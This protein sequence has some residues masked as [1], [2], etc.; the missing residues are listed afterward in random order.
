M[1]P[2]LKIN[3]KTKRKGSLQAS[4][5]P[6]VYS[7]T[8][9][10][11]TTSGKQM[12]SNHSMLLFNY[13]VS[14]SALDNHIKLYLSE[15]SI[16]EILDENNFNNTE[17]TYF[18]LSIAKVN[19]SLPITKITLIADLKLLSYS[20]KLLLNDDYIPLIEVNSS[21]FNKFLENQ[22]NFDFLNFNIREV[23]SQT[24]DLDHFLNNNYRIE[25]FDKDTSNDIKVEKKL[26]NG[27][28]KNNNITNNIQDVNDLFFNPND[29]IR[30]NKGN[31]SS[32]N[33]NLTNL[34]LSSNVPS[35]LHFGKMNSSMS[36]FSKEKTSEL[37]FARSSSRVS[38]NNLLP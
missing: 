4:K 27:M 18:L 23:N 17:L 7:M 34:N 26:S 9:N 33:S 16:K 15:Q 31:S 8:T 32:S 22:I 25:P 12:I 20:I 3:N 30:T 36:F 10:A 38:F 28:I 13:I 29:C 6:S 11:Y 1:K 24:N 19:F 37:P 21:S 14:S 5:T 2:N 35:F